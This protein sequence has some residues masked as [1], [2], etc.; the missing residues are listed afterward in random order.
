MPDFS[1]IAPFSDQEVSGVL[2]RILKNKQAIAGVATYLLP[3]ASRRYPRIIQTL[4]KLYLHYKILGISSLAKFQKILLAPYVTKLIGRSIQSFNV[5]G[6]EHL[7]HNNSHLFLSNHRDIASDPMLVDYALFDN[8]L[9]TVRIAIGDNLTNNPMIADLMRLNKSFIVR[10]SIEGGK[11]K[12]IALKHL[13]A[14]IHHSITQDSE[15]VWMAH[16]EGRAK[17][18]IDKTDIAV[19]KMLY[20]HQRKQ[21]SF[22]DAM[23]A[24][25]I[26]PVSIS[27]EYDPLIVAK[28]RELLAIEKTG[29][30]E[31]TDTED[32]QSTIKG[33]TGYKRRVSVS[34]CPP[35]TTE[36]ANSPEE[37]AAHLDTTIA[38]HQVIYPTHHLAHVLLNEGTTSAAYQQLKTQHPQQ[39]QYLAKHAENLSTD[40]YNKMLSIY[41]NIY[42]R[43][44]Q[45]QNKPAIEYGAVANK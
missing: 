8:N 18:G 14:Y 9:E 37:L 13:S 26:I 7:Q 24:L 16:R 34:F 25:N 38:A 35:I 31:K 22:A 2:R 29:N 23:A 45:Y 11:E 30:Y 43:A 33:L 44:M 36:Q 15:S 32:E 28:A 20:L 42:T 41:T 27:Y 4:I 10:R 21:T 17:D 5:K 12:L 6:L 40:V 19:L 1:D 3:Q 39:A